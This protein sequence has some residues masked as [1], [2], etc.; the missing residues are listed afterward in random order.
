MKRQHTFI[1][2]VLIGIG[3]FY[4]LKQ[5]NIDLLHGFYGWPTILMIIGIAFLINSIMNKDYSNIFTGTFLL[6]LGIHFHGLHHYT[7]W[8]EHWSVFTLLIGISL[9]TRSIWT[10]NGF[11]SGLVFTVISG[12]LLFNNQLGEMYHWSAEVIDWVYRL[13]PVV[14]IILGIY[15]L[16]R[17]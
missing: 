13:W 12:L 16:K 11:M 8:L 1:A 2:C 14:F 15:L 7:F 3:L 9:I 6:G 5:L 10:K 4:L 17:K